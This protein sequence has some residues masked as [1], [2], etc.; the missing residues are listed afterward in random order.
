VFLCVSL[1]LAL[2]AQQKTQKKK[3]K[4][5]LFFCLGFRSGIPGGLYEERN[6][7]DLLNAVQ[8]KLNEGAGLVGGA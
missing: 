2:V 8:D 7:S 6:H 5:T 4:K 3:H 1:T